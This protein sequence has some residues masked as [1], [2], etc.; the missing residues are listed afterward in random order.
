MQSVIYAVPLFNNY[1]R[2]T[3]NYYEAQD[4]AFIKAITYNQPELILSSYENGIQTLA[5]TLAANKSQ[6][7]GLPIDLREYYAS[8]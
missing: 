5:T 3:L 4:Q 2:P 8:M 7:T 6:D 1:L